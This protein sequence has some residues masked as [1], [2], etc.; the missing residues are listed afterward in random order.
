MNDQIVKEI[1]LPDSGA[2]V[3]I[4]FVSPM[5]LND[6]RKRAQ[7]GLE[8]PAPPLQEVDYG[9]GS[10][11]SQPNPLHPDYVAALREYNTAMG[12]KFIELM[13]K[14][15]VECDIDGEKVRAMRALAAE[16]EID[17]P[18]DDRTLYLTRILATTAADIEA[19]QD[20]ILGRAQP[21]E[22]AVSEKLETFQRDL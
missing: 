4:L 9:N 15:G 8:K 20:A 1:T 22:Q 21:T 10:K 19:L 17:L 18:A 7:R 11:K 6:L 5:L 16:D 13:F 12:Q 2:T 3:R 14:W